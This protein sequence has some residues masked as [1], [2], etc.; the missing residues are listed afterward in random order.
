VVRNLVLHPQ[1]NG[2]GHFLRALMTARGTTRLVR[3][4]VRLLLPTTSTEM[5]PAA[6]HVIPLC[7]RVNHGT[8]MV[9]WHV[10]MYV[11]VRTY[12]LHVCVP[13]CSST[14][15]HYLKNVLPMLEYGEW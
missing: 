2:R 12:V 11:H 15:V 3:G 4:L 10:H 9:P 13:W 14:M 1:H 6:P 7:L 5:A 8:I